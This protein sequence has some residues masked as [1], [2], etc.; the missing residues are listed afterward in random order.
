MILKPCQCLTAFVV[1][2]YIHTKYIIDYLSTLDETDYSISWQITMIRE[3]VQSR[4]GTTSRIYPTHQ[5][6]GV[7]AVFHSLAS[8][9]M[10][11]KGNI[12]NYKSV[13]PGGIN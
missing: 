13:G 12:C 7:S 10:S 8:G 3:S 2:E 11:H 9:S 6:N 5:Q 1:A 4:A